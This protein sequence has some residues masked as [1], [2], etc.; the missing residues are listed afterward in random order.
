MAKKVKTIIKMNLQAGSANPGPPLGPALAQH[1]VNLMEFVS[2]YNERTKDQR[3]ET[4][5]ALITVY[6]DGSFT[7]VL[8][9]APASA[10][11]LKS[12]KKDKGSGEPNKKKIG[13]ISAQDLEKIAQEKL[14]D[15]NTNDVEAAKKI[16]A[17]TARSM[18][19]DIVS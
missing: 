14:E 17:G 13:K 15:L 18:G 9:T 3:G 16:I 10:L 19:I 2:A 4:V 7:F 12:M 8:K 1:R 6:E 11:L 5:P